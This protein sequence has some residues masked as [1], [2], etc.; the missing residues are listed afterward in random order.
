MTKK[1][2]T[3]R[4]SQFPV[5]NVIDRRPQQLAERYELGIGGSLS[6]GSFRDFT[7]TYQSGYVTLDYCGMPN[8]EI[9]CLQRQIENDFHSFSRTT[10]YYPIGTSQIVIFERKFKVVEVNPYNI[11]L[12]DIVAKKK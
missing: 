9:F 4:D 7:G 11:T 8:P 10:L 3:N 1:F 12:E 2:K 5:I 6:V